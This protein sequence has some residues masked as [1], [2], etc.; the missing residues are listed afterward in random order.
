[1]LF[2]CSAKRQKS[3]YVYI[4]IYIY[5]NLSSLKI[6]IILAHKIV[7]LDGNIN[8]FG[9]GIKMVLPQI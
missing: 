9:W 4:Y 3:L 5:I 1:M 6:D 7:T 2:K 8:E